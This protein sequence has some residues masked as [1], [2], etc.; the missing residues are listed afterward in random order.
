MPLYLSVHP[1]VKVQ[2]PE[3][4]LRGWLATITSSHPQPLPL[5]V[6]YCMLPDLQCPRHTCPVSPQAP[7]LPCC[8]PAGPFCTAWENQSL[9][10]ISSGYHLWKRAHH[11]ITH[12]RSSLKKI[13][14]L[15]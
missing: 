14:K 10:S 2:G 9:G 4:P 13:Q 5:S 7:I 15:S 8:K 1:V 11:R 6:L 3:W 12:L